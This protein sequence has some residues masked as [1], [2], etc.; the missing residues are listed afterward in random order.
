MKA[1]ILKNRI[2]LISYPS[3]QIEITLRVPALNIQKM[4]DATGSTIKSKNEITVD[5]NHY[6]GK[7]YNV[8]ILVRFDKI[9]KYL[10][11]E[12]VYTC[13]N[14]DEYLNLLNTSYFHLTYN[15]CN[16]LADKVA[17][18]AFGDCRQFLKANN[19]TVYKNKAGHKISLAHSE[20]NNFGQKKYINFKGQWYSNNI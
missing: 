11:T 19:N 1:I 10:Q 7:L 13:V 14:K 12:S 17:L 16:L 20:K 8:T 15:E 18:Y 9:E 2:Q 3:K 6:A 5:F 4:I